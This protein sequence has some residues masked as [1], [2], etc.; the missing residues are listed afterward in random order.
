VKALVTDALPKLRECYLTALKGAPALRG[1]MMVRFV[2]NESGKITNI[3]EAASTTQNPALFD[4]VKGIIAAIPFPKPGGTAT[5]MLP[6][7]FK[8]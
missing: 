6:I 2:A 8:Q 4:C 1:K 5:V 7:K 3:E